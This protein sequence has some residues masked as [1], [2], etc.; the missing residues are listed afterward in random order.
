MEDSP[1]KVRALELLERHKWTGKLTPQFKRH[2]CELVQKG[3]PPRVALRRTGITPQ[4][5]WNWEKK[6]DEGVPQYVALFSALDEA[7]AEWQAYV[8]GK[9]PEH[10][11]KDARMCVEVAGRI[12]PD[13]Y[14]KK[15][16]ATLT[17]E[18]GPAL[19]ELMKQLNGQSVP[20]LSLPD[21]KNE[22]SLPGEQEQKV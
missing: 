5:V 11:A 8:A 17:Y 1:K 7:W 4:C 20:W 18:I 16:E 21:G 9:L 14:G 2:A 22:A 12:M 15:D 3:V 6:R 13:E 19:A 10:V